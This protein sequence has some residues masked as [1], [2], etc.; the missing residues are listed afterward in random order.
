[1]QWWS[2]AEI[3]SDFCNEMVALLGPSGKQNTANI[4]ALEG[5]SWSKDELDNLKAQFNAVTCTPEYPGGYIIARY[6]NFAF[7]DV[8]NNGTDPVETLLSYIDSINAELTRKRQE[9][10]LPT[11][12]EFPLD[13]N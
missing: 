2:S 4:E 1:M 12:D 9:F 11:A 3:Q 10:D 5:M 7:L 8:Y 13:T 6:A